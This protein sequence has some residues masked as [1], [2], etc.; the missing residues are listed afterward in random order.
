MVKNFQLEHTE[1][2]ERVY[3]FKYRNDASQVDWLAARALEVLRQCDFF[4]N[5]DVMTCVPGTQI[6]RTY[7]PVLLFSKKLAPALPLPFYEILRKTRA[8][9]SQKEMAT[10]EQKRRNVRNAFAANHPQAV[11]G[12]TILLVDD[13]YD[14]GATVDECAR[15]LKQ[16]GARAVYVLTLTKTGHVAK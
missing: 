9:R 8:T 1:I 4:A 16:A 13:L 2:G 6:D 3:R 7:E 5:L 15:I 14:S 10:K 11:A 12:R